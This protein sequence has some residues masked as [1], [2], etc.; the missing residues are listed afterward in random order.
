MLVARVDAVEREVAAL[1]I[2]AQVVE[3]G[4]DGVREER[5]PGHSSLCIKFGIDG[6][7]EK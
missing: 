4:D 1:K 7:G 5:C 6:D 3:G 2:I